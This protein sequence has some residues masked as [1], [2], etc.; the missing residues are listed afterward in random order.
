[1]IKTIFLVS[2]FLFSNQLFAS[3]CKSDIKPFCSLS[4]TYQD[5]PVVMEVGIFKKTCGLMEGDT[6]NHRCMM[7]RLCSQGNSKIEQTSSIFHEVVEHTQSV[8]D[9]PGYKYL[10]IDKNTHIK[11]KCSGI[12]KKKV[13]VEMVAGSK[14]KSCSFPFKTN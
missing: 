12:K 7:A 8:C 9:N 3:S 10:D 11:F 5:N 6:N 2:T 13:T 14:K 4:F 1:M